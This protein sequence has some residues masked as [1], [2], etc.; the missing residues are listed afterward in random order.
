[1]HLLCIIFYMMTLLFQRV[2]MFI[3]KCLQPMIDV[4]T[5]DGFIIKNKVNDDIRP[6]QSAG[7]TLIAFSVVIDWLIDWFLLHLDSFGDILFLDLRESCTLYIHIFC[8]FLR[9][10]LRTVIWYLDFISNTNYLQKRSI[11]QSEW[12]WK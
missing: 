8:S 4:C 7:F 10:I 2:L 3:Q 9:V 12:N 6:P 1:M 5:Y 11:W